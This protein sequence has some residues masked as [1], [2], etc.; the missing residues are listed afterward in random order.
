MVRV[1]VTG[2]RVLAEVDRIR[3]GVD[4]GLI[5]IDRFVGNHVMAVFSPLAEGA[6]RLVVQ[7]ILIR[8]GSRLIVPLP[9]AR[10][11]YMKDFDSEE[12][13]R[14]FLDLLD[15]AAEV[16]ELPPQLS[17]SA[18]YAAAGCYVLDHCDALLA[19]WDGNAAQ[20]ASGTAEVVAEARRRKMPIAWVHAGNRRPGTNEP[21]SLDTEQGTV[22]FENF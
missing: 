22:T 6:D 2:H 13:R 11:E 16:V 10:E 20:G 17:R 19:V 14:E 21:T 18:A 7:R 8:P 9:L 1:G 15:R 4:E 3:A 5:R 12:A